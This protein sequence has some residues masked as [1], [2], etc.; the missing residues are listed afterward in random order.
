MPLDPADRLEK[1][2]TPLPL[3]GLHDHT[4]TVVEVEPNDTSR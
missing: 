3:V 1:R 2:P 4:T